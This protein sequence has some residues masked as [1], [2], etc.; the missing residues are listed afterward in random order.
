MSARNG[1]ELA[2][3]QR[4][5]HAICRLLERNLG[6]AADLQAAALVVVLGRLTRQQWEA[7]AVEAKVNPPTWRAGKSATVEAILEEF[8]RRAERQERDVE[9]LVRRIAPPPKP[10]PAPVV[11]TIDEMIR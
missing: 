2:G 10:R 7:L 3:R 8:Q 4:K 5:V 9:R 11:K 1:F 6:A